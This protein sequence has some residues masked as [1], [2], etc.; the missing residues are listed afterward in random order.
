M[1][2]QLFT[3]VVLPSDSWRY[4][5]TRSINEVPVTNSRRPGH[6]VVAVMS[7]EEW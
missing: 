6:T 1:T 4:I 2:S 7:D 5:L 3:N